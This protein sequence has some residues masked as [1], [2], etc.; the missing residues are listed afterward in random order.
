MD[1]SLI[2]PVRNNIKGLKVALGAFQLFTAK[3]EL[4]EIHLLVDNDDPDAETYFELA[5]NYKLKI[6]IHLVEP[7]DHFN[8]DYYNAH[9]K[10]CRGKNIMAWNDDCY[11]QTNAWDDIVRKKIKEHPEFNGVYFV[12]MYDSTR[13]GSST[14]LDKVE[15]PRFPM[16]S[17]K[18]VDIAEYFFHPALR[19]WPADYVIHGVYKAV[20][21]IIKCLS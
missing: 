21:C 5:L 11:M 6:F 2:M 10:H 9:I 3:P 1:F 16:I 8:R 12:D 14:G 19:N 18:A 4:F 15:F 20:G 13:W 17:R 7:S